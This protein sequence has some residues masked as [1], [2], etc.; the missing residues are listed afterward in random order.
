MLTPFDSFVFDVIMLSG[1]LPFW[2]GR[3]KK[4]LKFF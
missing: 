4:N 3:I 2:T 1:S